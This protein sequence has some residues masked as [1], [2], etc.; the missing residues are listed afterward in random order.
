[1]RR[2]SSFAAP[3]E[4]SWARSAKL[5]EFTRLKETVQRLEASSKEG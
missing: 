3:T 5:T 1:M 4:Q 2:S